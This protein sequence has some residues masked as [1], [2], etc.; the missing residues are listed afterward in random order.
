MNN[1]VTAI[2]LA[3][4]TSFTPFAQAANGCIAPEEEKVSHIYFA[5][6]VGNSELDALNS[7]NSIIGAYKDTLDAREDESYQ[8]MTAYNITRG[9]FNDLMEVLNQK[10]NEVLGVTGLTAYQ[11]W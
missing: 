5:N 6:G 7:L 9:K 2:A 10:S 4:V 3:L 11:V 8:L 1:K